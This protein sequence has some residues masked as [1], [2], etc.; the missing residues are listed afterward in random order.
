MT[1]RLQ[2]L[3]QIERFY[4]DIIDCGNAFTS[5]QRGVTNIDDLRAGRMRWSDQVDELYEEIRQNGLNPSEF[6]VELSGEGVITQNLQI[7]DPAETGYSGIGIPADEPYRRLGSFE[8]PVAMFS[9]VR[10]DDTLGIYNLNPAIE[11]GDRQTAI[12][13]PYDKSPQKLGQAIMSLSRLATVVGRGS[14]LAIGGE[15]VNVRTL[16]L[17]RYMAKEY[18]IAEAIDRVPSEAALQD[19]LR[20]IDDGIN[21]ATASED[22]LD[23]TG[24]KSIQQLGKWSNQYLKDNPDHGDAIATAVREVLQSRD[25]MIVGGVYKP[26]ARGAQLMQLSGEL[27]DVLPGLPQAS[28]KDDEPQLTLVIQTQTSQ[29]SSVTYYA[30]LQHIEQLVPAASN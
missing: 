3:F 22:G 28:N 6:P 16:E 10:A 26:D 21:D 1:N 27:I 9:G 17:S 18:A 20:Q 8:N 14:Y 5:S 12:F 7:L 24:I 30:P 25:L 19:Y 13:L 23:P 11:A 4:T 29:D 15:Q 2:Q